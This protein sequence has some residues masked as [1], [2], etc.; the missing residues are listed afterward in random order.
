MFKFLMILTIIQPEISRLT[1]ILSFQFETPKIMHFIHR[2]AVNKIYGAK[3]KP[4]RIIRVLPATFTVF[5][6]CW[7]TY[8]QIPSPY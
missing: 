1:V 4:C 6:D 8:P 2:R 7:L 5:L 3:P